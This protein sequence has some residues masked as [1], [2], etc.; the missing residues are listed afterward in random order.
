[1]DRRKDIIKQVDIRKTEGEMETKFKVVM[2]KDAEVLK[3]FISFTYRAKGA[4]GRYKMRVLALGLVIIGVLA[5]K[6]G[7]MTAGI[8]MGAI[9]VLFLVFSMFL[10]QIAVLRLKK[11]DLAY[12]NQTELTYAFTNGSIY[13]YE[14]GEL[15]QNV[16]GYNNVSCFY[17]DEK[18]YYVGV[19]NDD[20]YLLP[21]KYFVEG[22]EE[23]FLE[24][25]EKKSNEKYEFLP[26]TMKNKW[27]VK[28]M[29]M[30]QQDLEYNERAAK[31][32]AED[33]KKKEE[34]KANRKSK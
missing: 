32:R 22:K 13:V 17:G 26:M 15:S 33:K 8:V 1:M 29:E 34:R 23:E 31:L 3:D 21:K 10:P 9:G 18:N 28:K 5:A 25:I 11:A 30:R 12:Q 19:N 6:G 2:K 4:V 7:S 24:F 20:L 14:N 27:M 16:G